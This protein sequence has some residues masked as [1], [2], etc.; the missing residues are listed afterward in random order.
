MGNWEKLRQLSRREYWLLVQAC[1]ALPLIALGLRLR[2]F[3][4]VQAGLNKLSPADNGPAGDDQSRILQTARLVR[5]AADHAFCR[6]NCL[7]RS[8]TLWW[9]LRRQGIA[10]TLRIGARKGMDRLEAHAWVEKDG[11]PLNERE[12]VHT[13]FPAFEKPA[14]R[15]GKDAR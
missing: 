12:D 15:A 2:G 9:L 4:A 6:V 13:H 14:E 3:N 8:L 7:P 11:I 1:V 5:V 10:S